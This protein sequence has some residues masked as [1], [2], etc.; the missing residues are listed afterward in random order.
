MGER[1]YHGFEPGRRPP[2]EVGIGGRWHA[3]ELRAWIRRNG[4]WW[5]HVDYSIAEDGTHTATVP[6]GSIRSEDTR[7]TPP[8]D[9]GV[10]DTTHAP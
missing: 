5:A 2:I 1:D 7:A 9:A 8:P 6:A 3:G 4:G 10:E